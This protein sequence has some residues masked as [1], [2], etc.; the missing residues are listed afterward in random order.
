ML[1]KKEENSNKRKQ[2]KKEGTAQ[3]RVDQTGQKK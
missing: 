2:T 3:T 1:T